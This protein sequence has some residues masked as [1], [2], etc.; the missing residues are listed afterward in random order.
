[1]YLNR[2]QLKKTTTTRHTMGEPE[3]VSHMMKAWLELH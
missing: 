3:K 2:D 1:M